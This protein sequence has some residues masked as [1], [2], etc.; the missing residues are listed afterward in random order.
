[1]GKWTPHDLRLQFERIVSDG[2]LQHF[3]D[4]SIASFIPSETLIA[5][6][7]RESNI[8]QIVGDG[9]NGYGI[10]Q[11]DVRSFPIFVTSNAWKDVRQNIFMG[12][13]VL[14]DKRSDLVLNFDRRISIGPDSKGNHALVDVPRVEHLDMVKRISLAMYNGGRWAIYQYVNYGNPDRTTTGGDYSSDVIERE[15][16]FREFLEEIV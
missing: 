14:S 16:L 12:A 11:I 10:M 4:A 5:I 8:T 3:F 1:M 13:S 9:G 2:W 7:S 15:E 6:A